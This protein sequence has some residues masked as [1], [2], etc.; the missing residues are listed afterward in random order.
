[1]VKDFYE[2]SGNQIVSMSDSNINIQV[3]IPKAPNDVSYK[4][5]YENLGFT[6][7]INTNNE[8]D[9]A[10]YTAIMAQ[11]DDR[12]GLSN[13]K[14]YIAGTDPNNRRSHLQITC[15]QGAIIRWVSQP[16]RTYSVLKKL[17]GTSEFQVVAQ[18]IQSTPPCNDFNDDSGQMGFYKIK[19][20]V[21]N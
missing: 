20:E 15:L 11:D 3:E 17:W 2:P 16:N 18:N 14:E 8:Q 19:V 6:R 13:Y 12:D 10:E 7:T 21:I 4:W 9:V 1:M 5:L